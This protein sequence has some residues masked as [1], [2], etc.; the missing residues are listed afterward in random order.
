MTEDTEA[1]D[2]IASRLN[3]DPLYLELNKRTINLHTRL[4]GKIKWI[5]PKKDGIPVFEPIE[6]DISDED[7][8]KEI[9]SQKPYGE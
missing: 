2:Q 8:K 4:K 5:G 6:K 9:C 1:A 3:S 7:L